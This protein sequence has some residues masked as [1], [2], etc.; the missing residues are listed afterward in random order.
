M[1]SGQEKEVTRC[2][3][4][5]A[6]EIHHSSNVYTRPFTSKLFLETRRLE[7]NAQAYLLLDICYK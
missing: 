4:S 3:I 2:F 7:V 1:F 5:L 6:M